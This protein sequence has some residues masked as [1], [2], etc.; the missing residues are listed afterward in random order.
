MGTNGNP[1]VI[2]NVILAPIPQKIDIKI[3]ALDG[4]VGVVFTTQV[5]SLDMNPLEAMQLAS[6]L[7]QK[8]IMVANG[9][10]DS[11]IVVPH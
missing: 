11:R 6:V 7:L 4:K 2:E 9:Q 3:A 10:S 5:S 1:P 8:A